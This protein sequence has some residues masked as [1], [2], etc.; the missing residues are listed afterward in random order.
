MEALSEPPPRP[1]DLASPRRLWFW[2]CV[3]A[4]AGV[5]L[6]VFWFSRFEDR[7]AMGFGEVFSGHLWAL[8]TAEIP[9]HGGATDSLT[10]TKAFAPSYGALLRG[11][12]E[13]AGDLP[14]MRFVLLVAQSTM[15]AAATLLTFALSRRVLFGVWALWPCALMTASV[16][17][18]ELPGG[19]AP[20]VPLMLLLVLI[21]WILTL[22]RERTRELS[23]GA[24]EVVLT[25]AAGLVLGAALLFNPAVLLLALP[26]LWWAFRGIGREYATLLLVATILLPAS[27]MAVA[28]SVIPGSLPVEQAR[29]WSEPASGNVVANA[30]EAVDRAYAVITPW[31]P[32][33]ARG[34]WSSGNWDYEWIMPHSIRAESTY[35]AATRPLAVILMVGYL[36]LVLA[37][38]VALMAE[39]AG[40]AARLLALP[41]LTL[42]LVTFLSPA[43]NLL[44]VPILPFL[45]ICAAVG[46]A[47]LLSSADSDGE[48]PASG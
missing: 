27:W 16:A 14:T 2:A 5:A 40:S 33:F 18:I 22:L 9:P 31:N 48:D 43:G 36:L 37:G 35:R 30:D 44:R 39:G 17:L 15:A 28:D 38:A 7:L 26:L 4:L 32:R 25:V 20:Q 23:R 10:L 45:M 8:P 12:W 34:A 47:W 19:L 29:T 11:A 21:A 46:A 41:V 13:L 6:R 24:G 1:L 42:P 3:I